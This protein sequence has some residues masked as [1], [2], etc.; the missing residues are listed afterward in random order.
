MEKQELY[1]ILGENLDPPAPT[2]RVSENPLEDGVASSIKEGFLENAFVVVASPFQLSILLD[3]G[4]NICGVDTTHLV[5]SYKHN[6]TTLLV[7]DE[8]K[9]GVP[10]AFCVSKR[11]DEWTYT[12]FFETLRSVLGFSITCNFFI[13]DGDMTIYK[14]WKNIMGPAGESRLCWWHVKHAWIRY[15]KQPLK[16]NQNTIK[17]IIA[18]LDAINAILDIS[19]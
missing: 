15:M 17:T 9:E 12:K 4:Q 7:M 5:S 3:Y 6:L 16:M 10:V 1:C 13:S 11:K 2:E 18:E 19:K 14:A 8:R